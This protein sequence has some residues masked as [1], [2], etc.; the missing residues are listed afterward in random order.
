M[1]EARPYSKM[2]CVLQEKE[3]RRKKGGPRNWQKNIPTTECLD[4]TC[5]TRAGGSIRIGTH[6][7]QALTGLSLSIKSTD[8][9]ELFV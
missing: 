4:S 1:S 5:R 7:A 2:E 8:M 9:F 6:M 3:L